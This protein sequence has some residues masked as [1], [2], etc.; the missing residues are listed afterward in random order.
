MFFEGHFVAEL[1]AVL[2]YFLFQAPKNAS[3]AGGV[4]IPIHPDRELPAHGPALSLPQI[5]LDRPA[6]S[7]QTS[8]IINDNNAEACQEEQFGAPVSFHGAYVKKK[9]ISMSENFSFADDSPKSGYE[10]C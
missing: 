6:I 4:A 3:S 9:S 1:P 5:I 7:L 10:N 2:H 8:D